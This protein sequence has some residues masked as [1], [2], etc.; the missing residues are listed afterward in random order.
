MSKALLFVHSEKVPVRSQRYPHLNLS[1]STTIFPTS[2]REHL[3]RLGKG[4][5]M[6]ADIEDKE[7]DSANERW[8]KG[9]VL[10]VPING[11][12]FRTKFADELEALSKW[13]KR[14]VCEGE[15]GEYTRR[16]N[17][18]RK[19]TESLKERLFDT[20]AAGV[21]VREVTRLAQPG[22]SSER[23]EGS[24]S[25]LRKVSSKEQELFK[26]KVAETLIRP[27]D[28]EELARELRM[29]K[30]NLRKRLGLLI[31]GGLVKSTTQR[32]VVGRPKAV[33]F[34]AHDI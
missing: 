16:L 10:L 8:L 32:L 20:G 19:E 17:L 34:L 12:L 6:K 21:I 29:N 2:A 18:L 3:E 15:I 7:L 4:K 33:Y 31:R 13:A 28:I 23:F 25:N 5:V 30:S 1:R 11:E 27:L 24:R 22:S 14:G 26:S 9:K